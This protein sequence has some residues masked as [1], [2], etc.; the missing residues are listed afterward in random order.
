MLFRRNLTWYYVFL[1]CTNYVMCQLI[2]VSPPPDFCELIDFTV[3]HYCKALGS[4]NMTSF[5]NAKKHETQN[6]AFEELNDFGDLI[7]TNCSGGIL[8]FLCSY[9]VPLCYMTPQTG[10]LLRLQPCQNLCEDVYD[11]CISIFED[12]GLDWP[13]HLNC[14]LF[15]PYPQSANDT[16]CFGPQDPSTL[17]L[18]AI[19]PG[20]NAPA[21]TET[22]PLTTSSLETTLLTTS[23]LETT[24]LTTS[25]LD[26]TT[27]SLETTLLTTS[28][29]DLTASST[30]T[31][32]AMVL[33]TKSPDETTLP[34]IQQ[35]DNGIALCAS[36]FT[37]SVCILFGFLY[38]VI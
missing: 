21:P 26:L 33:P 30:T 24:L 12:K 25:S 7:R 6:E 36:F 20:L 35:P 15:P 32:R 11:N 2:T 23:S 17:V 5:P 34:P 38:S 27:S 31:S 28:S 1:C 29:L 16:P 8:N 13:E 22:T 10:Q 4:Y 18:P 37:V 3:I 19:I 9:Y 14:S